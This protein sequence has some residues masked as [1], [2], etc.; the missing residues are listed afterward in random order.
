M[1]L[2]DRTI[3]PLLSDE[4]IKRFHGPVPYA[5]CTDYIT[6]AEYDLKQKGLYQ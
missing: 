1:N 5:V 3:I 6:F 4:D 2:N